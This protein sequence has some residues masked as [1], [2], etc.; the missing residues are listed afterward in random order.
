MPPKE[1][2]TPR[3]Q[4]TLRQARER[5]TTMIA[6]RWAHHKAFALARRDRTVALVLARGSLGETALPILPS[7][8][9]AAALGFTCAASG[10]LV[11]CGVLVAASAL[12][13]GVNV[14]LQRPQR[15]LA[16]LQALLR[17]ALLQ[18]GAVSLVAISAAGQRS[19]V[20]GTEAWSALHHLSVVAHLGL[21]WVGGLA[22]GWLLSWASAAPAVGHIGAVLLFVGIIFA[23]HVALR[24]ER[25]HA[26]IQLVRTTARDATALAGPASSH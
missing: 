2:P 20:W 22:A 26:A 6:L 8:F 21:L 14:Y 24:L 15:C 17:W 13:A 5:R 19:Q 25:I 23:L 11:A 16:K 18:S 10:L 3:T 9:A 4:A 7:A 1:P 12:G